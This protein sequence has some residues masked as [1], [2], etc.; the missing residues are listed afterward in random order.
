MNEGTFF[1]I[2]E[3]SILQKT[4]LSL[5][6]LCFKDKSNAKDFFFVDYMTFY[7]HVTALLASVKDYV[8]CEIYS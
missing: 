5:F 4:N 1:V 8:A 6:F 3:G 7:H 2:T